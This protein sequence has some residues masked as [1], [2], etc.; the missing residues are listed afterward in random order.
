STEN[1]DAIA[2]GPA[3]VEG[4]TTNVE[5]PRL[6]AASAGLIDPVSWLMRSVSELFNLWEMSPPRPSP[7]ENA[8]GVVTIP[9]VGVAGQEVKG[10]EVADLHRAFRGD[11][12]P[13]RSD[14][15]RAWVI[16]LTCIGIGTEAT[17][18]YRGFG[19]RNPRR[20]ERSGRA[21]LG[22]AR[23]SSWSSPSRTMPRFPL[24]R[25]RGDL[26]PG[27]LVTAAK[28]PVGK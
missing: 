23:S 16:I 7:S 14:W 3:G 21:P 28:V 8:A 12:G 27:S 5:L 13:D 24:T 10:S 17:A 20:G 11:A 2:G 15:E 19:S 26:R 6:A 25:R 9:A 1:V 18:R 4:E 22:H